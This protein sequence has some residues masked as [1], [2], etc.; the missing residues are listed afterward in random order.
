MGAPFAFFDA[1]ATAP[2]PRVRSPSNGQAGLRAKRTRPVAF[3]VNDA[4][5]AE[6]RAPQGA[7]LMGLVGSDVERVHWAEPDLFL[8]DPGYAATAN[9]YHHV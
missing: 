7:E 6:L 9:A 5:E 8:A 2:G 1:L 4:E 3:G